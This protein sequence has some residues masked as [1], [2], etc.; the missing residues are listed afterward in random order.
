[1]D[2]N[3]CDYIFASTSATTLEDIARLKERF[4]GIDTRLI[5]AT[6][7]QHGAAPVLPDRHRH[8]RFQHPGGSAGSIEVMPAPASLPAAPS[9]SSD[10]TLRAGS[11]LFLADNATTGLHRKMAHGYRINAPAL[12][13]QQ[14]LQQLDFSSA[15]IFEL[16]PDTLSGPYLLLAQRAE[17]ALPATPS[18]RGY[19]PQLGSAGRPE[20][21]LGTT[22]RSLDEEIAGA[23]RSRRTSLPWRHCPH[24]VLAAGYHRQLWTTRRH[25][26][27][28]RALAP[29][30]TRPRLKPFWTSRWLDAPPP[31]A[32]SRLAKQP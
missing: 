21:L 11:T 16:S 25:R 15:E 4:P 10:N 5:G 22:V 23:W 3:C 32:S 18:R 29:A 2:F 17:S 19:A 9:L 12:F 26:T 14:Q 28:G 31:P 6:S 1:M 27:P 30:S 8:T 24:R 13:W 20:R 7:E